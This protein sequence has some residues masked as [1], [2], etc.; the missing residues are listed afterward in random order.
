MRRTVAI[1]RKSV[2]VISVISNLKTVE[3][4][5]RKMLYPKWLGNYDV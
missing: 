3:R 1:C 5:E 4:V 2:N